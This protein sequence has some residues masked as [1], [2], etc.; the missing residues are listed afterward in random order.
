MRTTTITEALAELKTLDKRLQS[1]G[2]FIAENSCRP[3]ALADALEKDGGSPKLVAEALQSYRDLLK[4][5]EEIRLAIMRSN[6]D[7]TLMVEGE[8]RTVFSWLTWRRE[9]A[10][11]EKALLVNAQKFIRE[12]RTKTAAWQKDQAGIDINII[13]HMSEK[14]LSDRQ[15]KIEKMLGDLDGK[16]SLF[17]ATTTIEIN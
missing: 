3:K 5:R 2:V 12:V 13:T 6:I 17:N 16:L 7:K 11:H 8:I 4:G 15:E 14:E 10:P 1:K 9:V